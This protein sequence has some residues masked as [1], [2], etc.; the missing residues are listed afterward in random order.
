[1][2]SIPVE[3]FPVLCTV[4]YFHGL[5]LGS[6][7]CALR[8][9]NHLFLLNAD[10]PVT[11]GIVWKALDATGAQVMFTVPYTLKFFA[12]IEG[13]IERLAALDHVMAGGAAT[14]DD[15]GEKLARAGV[16]LANGYGQTESG[17][18]MRAV[19]NG[20]GEWCWLSPSPRAEKFIKFEKV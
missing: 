6:Y 5:G 7:I 4:P 15:L 18:L 9:A 10:R 13:G 8:G 20:P 19:N 2:F 16:K 3:T 11:A 17:L 12:D 1:M 14:P